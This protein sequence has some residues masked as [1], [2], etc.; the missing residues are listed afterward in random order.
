[1]LDQTQ[2]S[3]D[4]AHQT[5]VQMLQTAVDSGAAFASLVHTTHEL[6][7]LFPTVRMSGP[8]LLTTENNISLELFLG[9][10]KNEV[11]IPASQSIISSNDASW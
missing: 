3:L 10:E 5:S 6:R 7:A 4:V 9:L 1:M 11:K 2:S 8:Y